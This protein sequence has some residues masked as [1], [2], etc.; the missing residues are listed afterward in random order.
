MEHIPVSVAW[1]E[2]IRNIS[3]PPGWDASP[4]QGY[5]NIKFAGTHLYTWVERDIISVLTEICQEHNTMSQ[6]LRLLDLELTTLTMRPLCIHCIKNCRI[7][8]GMGCSIFP[9]LSEHLKQA[10]LNAASMT[11]PLTKSIGPSTS[12]ATEPVNIPHKKYSGIVSRW[13]RRSFPAKKAVI[14]NE[15]Y[16]IKNRTYRYLCSLL[17]K[18]IR[19]RTTAH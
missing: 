18:W 12:A 13:P 14:Y 8:P 6:G 2:A 4:S 16:Y 1:S 9:H 15:K 17:T 11:K 7:W 19:N 3:T 10:N 5:P